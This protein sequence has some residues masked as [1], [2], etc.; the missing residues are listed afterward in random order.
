MSSATDQRDW[1]N[2]QT[3]NQNGCEHPSCRENAD[4]S[5]WTASTQR[6]KWLCWA[7]Y[8]EY[9]RAERELARRGNGGNAA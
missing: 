2:W 4:I 8:E 5:L 9:Q 1:Q 3:T 6:R 7:H